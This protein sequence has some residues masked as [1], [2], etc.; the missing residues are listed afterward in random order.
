MSPVSKRNCRSRTTPNPNS[1]SNAGSSKVRPFFIGP[2]LA[3]RPQT[4]PRRAARPTRPNVAPG[5]GGVGGGS[6]SGLWILYL[7]RLDFHEVDLKTLQRLPRH[8]MQA[9]PDAVEVADVFGERVLQIRQRARAT[10]QFLFVL[11][12]RFELREAD[13]VALRQVREAGEVKRAERVAQFAF[14]QQ[15][16]REPQPVVFRQ[17][18][19]SDVFVGQIRNRNHRFTGDFRSTT[20]LSPGPVKQNTRGAGGQ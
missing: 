9:I 8:V 18:A 16:A 12:V 7:A 20:A 15:L 3:T 5:L 10:P 14:A 1:A 17:L 13:H 11:A 6:G 2:D 19:G 4:T